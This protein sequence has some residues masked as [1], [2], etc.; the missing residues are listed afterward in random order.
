[1]LSE[2]NKDRHKALKVLAEYLKTPPRDLQL[3]AILKDV[4]DKDLRWVNEKIHYYLLRLL[5][6][7]EHNKEEEEDLVFITE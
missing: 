3:C 1:M 5:E 2:L 7:S 4:K 6:E